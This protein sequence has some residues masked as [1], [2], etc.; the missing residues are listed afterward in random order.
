VYYQRFSHGCAVITV[1]TKILVR[2]KLQE[3]Q[4]FYDSKTKDF[5]DAL[6]YHELYL[7]HFIQDNRIIN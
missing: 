2:Y 5:Y 7:Y 1:K 3:M 4:H 6:F